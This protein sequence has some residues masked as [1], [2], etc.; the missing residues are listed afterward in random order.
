[1]NVITHCKNCVFAKLNADGQQESCA[2]NRSEKL[3]VEKIVDGSFELKR[4]CNTFRPSEWIHRLPFEKSL[5]PENSVM[6]EVYPRIGFF[7]KLK[8]NEQNAIDALELTINSISRI[9]NGPAAYV[10]VI[11]DKVEYNE[12]IWGLFIKY[13]GETSKT[14][15]HIV[16]IEEKPNK[17][18]EIIDEAFGRAQNS[19]IMCTSSGLRIRPETLDRLHDLLNKEMKQIAI[20]EPYD[21]FNGFMFPAY[22]FK[23]LN[24]NRTKVFRDEIVDSN[25]FIQ[26]VRNAEERGKTKTIMT[27]SEFN[28]I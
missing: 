3:G 20:V 12:E 25:E 13:F 19:W 28:A 6:E 21:D 5:N 27:W 10:V 2:L 23:F 4:Y 8:T 18:T 7:I 17:I 24:G 22:L 15:Y 26:K 11:N 1:M 9:N 16:Q 14:K